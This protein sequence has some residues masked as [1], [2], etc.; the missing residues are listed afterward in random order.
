MPNRNDPNFDKLYKVRPMVEILNE[1]FKS[2]YI[3]D[4]CLAIDESMEGFKG[5][6]SLKHFMP[7]RP[8]IR[9]IKNWGIDCSKTGYL[10]GFGIYEGKSK[11][12]DIKGTL[13]ERVVLKLSESYWERATVS[14]LIIFL[15]HLTYCQDY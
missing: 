7:M 9:G 15:A 13:G 14:S 10:L 2:N 3:P 1:S 6:I 5:R 8:T 12:D 4:R 11:R